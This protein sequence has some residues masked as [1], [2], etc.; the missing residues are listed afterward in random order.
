[1]LTKLN[2]A[3]CRQ[4][5]IKLSLPQIV[6]DIFDDRERPEELRDICES[7]YYIFSEL[8]ECEVP[9]GGSIT[10]IWEHSITITAYQHSLPNGRFIEFSLESPEDVKVLGPSFKCVVADLLIYLWEYEISADRLREIATQF[11]FDRVDELV[12]GC[13]ATNDAGFQEREEWHRKFVASC[14]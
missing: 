2:R 4:S 14:A 1:M 9:D 11:E 5:L 8:S 3:K 7:P 6:L 10:P 12:A 13:F